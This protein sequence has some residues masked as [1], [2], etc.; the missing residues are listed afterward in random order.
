MKFL[1]ANDLDEAVAVG[2]FVPDLSATCCL[3]LDYQEHPPFVRPGHLPLNGEI[4]CLALPKLAKEKN[5]L[6]R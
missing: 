6:P 4:S 1:A 2:P 3:K 5:D